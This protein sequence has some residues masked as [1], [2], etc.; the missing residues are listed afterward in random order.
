MNELTLFAANK[1]H[2]FIQGGGGG[3]GGGEKYVRNN[4][5]TGSIDQY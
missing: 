5:K 3:G 1:V 2:S 4:G